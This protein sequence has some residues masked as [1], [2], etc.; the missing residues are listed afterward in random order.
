MATIIWW[1]AVAGSHGKYSEYSKY[2]EYVSQRW[3]QSPSGTLSE[4]RTVIKAEREGTFTHSTYCA[5]KDKME[6][7]RSSVGSHEKYDFERITAGYPADRLVFAMRGMNG[8]SS[9]C[10]ADSTSGTLGNRLRCVY[11]SNSDPTTHFEFIKSPGRSAPAP[12]ADVAAFYQRGVN[13]QS[14]IE[15][16]RHVCS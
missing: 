15:N 13:R 16:N 7:S 1:N 10:G 6:C 3:Q 5:D 8:G 4:D 2:S 14:C 12:T 11:S 9:W